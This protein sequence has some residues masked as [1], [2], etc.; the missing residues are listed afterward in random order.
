MEDRLRGR[1]FALLAVTLL[2]GFGALAALLRAEEMW[3]TLGAF[4]AFVGCGARAVSLWHWDEIV[5]ESRRYRR[6]TP[7]NP[8][9]A[10]AIEPATAGSGHR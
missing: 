4:V 2:L 8:D 7:T 6:P 1:R 3:L 5:F 9:R 10:A